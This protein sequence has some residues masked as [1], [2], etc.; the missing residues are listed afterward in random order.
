MRRQS[1]TEELRVSEQEP[2]NRTALDD[3]MWEKVGVVRTGPDLEAALLLQLPTQHCQLLCTETG[4]IRLQ[5]V[6]CTS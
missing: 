4:A 5:T 6:R 1:W 2:I 3:L